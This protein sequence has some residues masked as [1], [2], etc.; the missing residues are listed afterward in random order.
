MVNRCYAAKQPMILSP[1]WVLKDFEL[2]VHNPEDH[3]FIG[4]SKNLHKHLG[5]FL[6][7]CFGDP[8]IEVHLHIDFMMVA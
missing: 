8:A 4:I 3:H 1:S 6:H 5:M 2:K 7:L